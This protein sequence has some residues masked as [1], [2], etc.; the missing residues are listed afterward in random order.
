MRD[1]ARIERMLG[2]LRR[3]WLDAPDLRLGQLV[4]H[5]SGPECWVPDDHVVEERMNIWLEHG[6]LAMRMEK[7][8]GSK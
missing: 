2:K 7:D 6:W 5:L 1:S 4:N 8:A 3:L